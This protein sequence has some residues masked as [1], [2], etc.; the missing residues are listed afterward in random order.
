MESIDEQFEKG[1]QETILYMK[2]MGDPNAL[3]FYETA[4]GFSLGIGSIVVEENSERG[5]Y[6]QTG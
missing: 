4:E 5:N 6:H 3:R 1:F 2:N